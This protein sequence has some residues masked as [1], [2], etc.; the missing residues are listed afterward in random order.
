MTLMRRIYVEDS[1]AGFNVDVVGE[2]LQTRV[3]VEA[4]EDNLNVDV[5]GEELQMRV[6]VEATEG[7]K[8][9]VVGSDVIIDPSLVVIKDFRESGVSG[10][11][12]ID[13]TAYASQFYIDT[14]VLTWTGGSAPTTIKAGWGFGQA[15]TLMETDISYLVLNTPYPIRSIAVPPFA[16]TG[17]YFTLP[18]GVLTI[19]IV[20]IRYKE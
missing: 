11:A 20:M 8:M 12:Y 14:I 16:T 15:N 7:M 2:K 13:I 1:D 17:V 3:F 4:S 9:T 6:F 5:V 10:T 18:T 19:D